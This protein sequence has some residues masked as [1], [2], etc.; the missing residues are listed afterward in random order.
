[1]V[2]HHNEWMTSPC[3]WNGSSLLIYLT[4]A[5]N[6]GFWSSKN[7]YIYTEWR[8]FNFLLLALVHFHPVLVLFGSPVFYTL[9]LTSSEVQVIFFVLRPPPPPHIK[10]EYSSLFEFSLC[11]SKK[12]TI[13]LPCKGYRVDPLIFSAV[14]TTQLFTSTSS[15]ETEHCRIVRAFQSSHIDGSVCQAPPNN[16]IPTDFS[17]SSCPSTNEVVSHKTQEQCPSG[18]NNCSCV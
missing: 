7:S 14:I 4:K 5:Q 12:F 2:R 3:G 8:T 13:V 11:L 18:T 9:C 10:I 17:R 6:S 15:L 16:A 1:M